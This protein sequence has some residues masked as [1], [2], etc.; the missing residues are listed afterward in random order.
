M[1]SIASLSMVPLTI[2]PRVLWFA[3]AC[4]VIDKILTGSIIVTHDTYTVINVSFTSFASKSIM[5]N[6]IK[7]SVNIYTGGIILARVAC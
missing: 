7:G 6:T 1:S 2:F 4:K 3:A 5:T